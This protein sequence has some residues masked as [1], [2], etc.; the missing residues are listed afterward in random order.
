M[1]RHADER[2][3]FLFSYMSRREDG[4]Q[5]TPETL[6][7]LAI[8]LTAPG[9][10][11][12]ESVVPAGYTYL[13]QLIAHDLS[14]DL[15]KARLGRQ[16][17]L[18]RLDQAA[19]PTLDLDTLYGGGPLDDKSKRFYVDGTGPLMVT[20]RTVAADVYPAFEGCDL[21]RGEDGVLT[22]A[23]IPDPRNDDNLGVAQTH[24]ALL[25]FHNRVADEETTASDPFTRFEQAR[26]IVT[27]HLQWIVWF[28][29]LPRICDPAVLADVLAGGRKAF[30]PGLDRSVPATMP[31][32]FSAGVFRLGH[33]MVRSTYDWNR[34]ATTL[35]IDDL[36]VFS[37][38]GGDLDGHDALPSTRTADFRRLYDF[39][40]IGRPHL[41]PPELNVARAIDTRLTQKLR[42]LPPGT[43]GSDHPPRRER[44]MNLA[45]RNL[46]KARSVG[47]ASGQDMARFL[48][49]K[50]VDL[51]PLTEQTISRDDDGMDTKLAYALGED[52]LR[53][54]PLWV[55]ALR[56]SER[57]KDRRLTGV[58]ARIVAETFH[59][60]IGASWTSIFDGSDWT[61]T[62]TGAGEDFS[63]AHLLLYA[64][65]P[66]PSLLAPLEPPL[67]S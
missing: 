5:L 6:G 55:Y 21:P 22:K 52:G 45:F 46:M 2:A 64:F 12:R 4:H 7:T 13:G 26:D 15:T 62:L 30:E 43:I 47:L 1:D 37:A 11:V 29:F 58:G 61:P 49:G 41:E 25:R 42:N 28:D 36:F 19:S 56:E 59:R 31:L 23:C 53:H 8:R 51:T 20:G 9:S 35:S 39:T 18:D 57:R 44:E 16:L 3:D 27:R 14:F 40:E 17:A 10:G 38:R 66:D 67:D 34:C 50:G 24:A 32:E 33:S 63:M 48:M 54:T 65:E 60:A